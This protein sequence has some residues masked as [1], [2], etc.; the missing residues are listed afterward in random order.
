LEVAKELGPG[1]LVVVVIC[2]SGDR[3]L[4]KCYDDDWMKDMGYLGPEQ[5]LGTVREVLHFKGGEV[6][7]AKPDETLA[8]VAKRMSDLGISQMPVAATD[9]AGPLKII[10]EVDLLQSLVDQR[11][12]PTDTVDHAATDLHGQVSIDDSLTAVQTVFDDE[13]VAVVVE[14]GGVTGVI[15]KIDVIEYLAAQR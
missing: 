14:D 9:E 10:H 15:S 3:Y 2:D 6:Q 11:C 4:S 5:L 13:N 7:F 12:T 8:S 1:K